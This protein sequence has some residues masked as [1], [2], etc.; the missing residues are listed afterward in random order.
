MVLQLHKV[1]ACSYTSVEAHLIS[2][3]K[4][5]PVGVGVQV[6]ASVL[7]GSAEAKNTIQNVKNMVGARFAQTAADK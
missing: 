5:L 3:N 7:A 2:S 6:K 4:P 1:G